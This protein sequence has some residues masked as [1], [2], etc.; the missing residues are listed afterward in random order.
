MISFTTAELECLENLFWDIAFAET[1]GNW[2]RDEEV[3]QSIHDK[4]WNE[5]AATSRKALFDKKVEE[6]TPPAILALRS[7]LVGVDSNEV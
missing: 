4:V 5:L 6:T 2:L 3:M 7:M 1:P